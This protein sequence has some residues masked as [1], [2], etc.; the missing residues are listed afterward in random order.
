MFCIFFFLP[1]EPI[2]PVIQN[3]SK[4][5]PGNLNGADQPIVLWNSSRLTPRFF[6]QNRANLPNSYCSTHEKHNVKFFEN[7]NLIF[8]GFCSVSPGCSKASALWMITQFILSSQRQ[9]IFYWHDTHLPFK[10]IYRSIPQFIHSFSGF[11]DAFGI[12]WFVENKICP[13]PDL[14]Q[15]KILHTWPEDAQNLSWVIQ[16]STFATVG[17]C[18]GYTLYTVYTD[19]V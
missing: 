19:T 11:P 10:N 16:L 1:Q 12:I 6:P 5:F 3:P 14:S 9:W 15:N 17:N 18:T 8:A 7:V 2:L 4:G 13:K